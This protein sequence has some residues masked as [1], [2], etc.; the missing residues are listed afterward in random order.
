RL[1]GTGFEESVH[2]NS[3][4]EKAVLAAFPDDVQ[5]V[6]SRIGTAEVATDP[7]GV[8]LTDFFITLKPRDQWQKAQTQA[9]LTELIVKELRELPGQAISFSQP[10]ELRINEMITGVRSD[11]AVKIFGDDL[12][13]L[14]D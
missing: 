14:A 1:G 6:W 3:R 12:H 8:E 10:I 9:E 2:Y 7:M 4:M 13:V 11:V 5:H